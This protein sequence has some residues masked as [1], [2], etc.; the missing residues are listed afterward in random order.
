MHLGAA[1]GADVL[2]RAPARE[3]LAAALDGVDRLGLLGGILELRHGPGAAALGGGGPAL[4]AIGAAMAG[5]V[6]VLVPG[7]HDHGLVRPWLDEVSAPGLEERVEPAAASPVAAAV[8]ERLAPARVEMAY[9]GLWLRE[10]VYATHGHYLDV[11]TTIP[12][13]ERLGAGLMPRPVGAPEPGA[14]AAD[15]EAVLAPIYAWIESAA[16]RTK[17]GRRAAGAG[18]SGQMWAAFA[19]PGRRPLRAPLIGAGFPVA[20]AAINRARLGPVSPDLSGAG[21]HR[22]GLAG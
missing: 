3:A 6:V 15:F 11:F 16:H 17:P 4:E 20:I 14:T 8:A 1:S 2:R 18:R 19:A 12:T 10:D 13:F 21:L 22:A 9:P 7:N 5:G